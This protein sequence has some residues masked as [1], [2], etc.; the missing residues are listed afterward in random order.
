MTATQSV[1]QARNKADLAAEKVANLERREQ[2]KVADRCSS[3]PATSWSI[4]LGGSLSQS[5]AKT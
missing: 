1:D 3:R 2:R 4:A 5:E